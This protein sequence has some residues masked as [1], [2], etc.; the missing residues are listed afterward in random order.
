MYFHQE[1]QRYETEKRLARAQVENLRRAA[2][3]QKRLVRAERR[4]R[5]A[6]EAARTVQVSLRVTA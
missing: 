1:Q 3:A 6:R 4:V 5:E 2:R